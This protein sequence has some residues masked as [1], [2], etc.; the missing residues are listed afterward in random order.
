M[1][2]HNDIHTHRHIVHSTNAKATIKM[3]TISLSALI[4]ANSHSRCDVVADGQ[5]DRQ[6][7]RQSFY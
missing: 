5:T 6:T 1:Y 3:L 7:E 4:R 2:S